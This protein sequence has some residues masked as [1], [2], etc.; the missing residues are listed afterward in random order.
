[1]NRVLV[2]GA[3]AYQRDLI[4]KLKKRGF[5]VICTDNIPNNIGHIYSDKSYQISTT[6]RNALLDL[7]K[8]ENVDAVMTHA[9]DVAMPSIGYINDQLG[10]K[11]VSLWQAET[12]TN[13]S[14]F[15]AFQ[16]KEGM[17]S[18]KYFHVDG[19]TDYIKLYHALDFGNSYII[20]PVDRSGSLGVHA[21]KA[22]KISAQ[23]FSSLIKRALEVSHTGAAI[24]EDL[25]GGHHFSAEGWYINGNLKVFITHQLLTSYPYYIPTGHITP[26]TTLS[27]FQKK[28]EDEIRFVLERLGATNTVFDVDGVVNEQEQVILIEMSL[29]TGGNFLPKVIELST[30]IDLISLSIDLALNK[31]TIPKYR[32][33]V[34]FAGAKLITAKRPG[35]VNRIIE[36]VCGGNSQK[37]W[38]YPTLKNGDYFKAF[39]SGADSLGHF[40]MVGNSADLILSTFDQIDIGTFYDVEYTD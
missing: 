25:I 8:S 19:G 16:K 4:V 37:M 28:I 18:P 39:E 9:S 6:N 32:N 20:K 15:R 30:G 14:N 11:G 22:G 13:K 31:T 3:G 35:K 12:L 23:L 1:M 27:F 7:A 2:L 34:R 36:F 33:G 24:V 5:Y 40:L 38:A 17:A 29:R 26:N 21:F 10:L